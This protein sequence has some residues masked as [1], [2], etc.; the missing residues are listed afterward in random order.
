[1]KK[2]QERIEKEGKYTFKD[3]TRC[4]TKLENSISEYLRFNLYFLEEERFGEN[5]PQGDHYSF[6]NFDRVFYEDRNSIIEVYIN[7]LK[8]DF[9]F[10][11]D[12]DE[13][14]TTEEDIID[15]FKEINEIIKIIK[16][17]KGE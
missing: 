12:S 1:M 14:L 11:N 2:I 5:I 9:E 8:I 16:L 4:N 3:I 6:Y 15:M 7:D 13:D 10:Y 17:I